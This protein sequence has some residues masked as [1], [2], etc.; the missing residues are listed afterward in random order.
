MKRGTIVI[1]S[2]GGVYIEP[3]S[4]GDDRVRV[5]R[6]AYRN[7]E[8]KL[9]D[10]FRVFYRCMSYSSSRLPVATMIDWS[11]AASDTKWPNE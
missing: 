9:E 6:L 8:R 4:E 7:S 1:T 3:Q 2:R 10:G 5:T 11:E